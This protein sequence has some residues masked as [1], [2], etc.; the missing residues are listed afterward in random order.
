MRPLTDDLLG[1]GDGVDRNKNQRPNDDFR[2][3][4]NDVEVMMAPNSVRSE[5]RFKFNN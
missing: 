2:D 1:T 5:R 3:E 4:I